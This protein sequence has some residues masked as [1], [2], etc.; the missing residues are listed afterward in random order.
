MRFSQ[1]GLKTIVGVKCFMGVT[2]LRTTQSLLPGRGSSA[3]FFKN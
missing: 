2:S 3:E 1:N